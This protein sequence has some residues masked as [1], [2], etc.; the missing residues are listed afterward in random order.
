[1]ATPRYRDLRALES[2]G[3]SI[4]GTFGFIAI[5][6]IYSARMGYK[7]FIKG[8]WMGSGANPNGAT[9]ALTSTA[10]NRSINGAAC[11]L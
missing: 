9:M 5:R 6:A 1:M 4:G 3:T 2:G 8:Q 7:V 10:G 11:A